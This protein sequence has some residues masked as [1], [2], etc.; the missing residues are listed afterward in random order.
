MK[1]FSF[2]VII[3]LILIT[4]ISEINIDIYYIR[5]HTTANADAS[6]P[7][8]IGLTMLGVIAFVCT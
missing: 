5:L 1:A 7:N 6:T 2:W 4:W 3:L 8:I